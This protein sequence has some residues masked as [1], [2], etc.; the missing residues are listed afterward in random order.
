[1]RKIKKLRPTD[2]ENSEI[3]L[4]AEPIN[5]NQVIVPMSAFNSEFGDNNE[6][7]MSSFEEYNFQEAEDDDKLEEKEDIIIQR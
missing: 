5:N 3:H 7:Q 2:E 4:S 6:I 1:M